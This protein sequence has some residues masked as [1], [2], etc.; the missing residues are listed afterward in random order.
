VW[1]CV[2]L[3]AL[4][5]KLLS[6]WDVRAHTLWVHLGVE[7]ARPITNGADVEAE[8]IVMW[9]GGDREGMPFTFGH[10]KERRPVGHRRG[11]L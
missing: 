10:L 2:P 5:L 9:R 7:L 6:A 4:L 3:D 1:E 11:L 8:E